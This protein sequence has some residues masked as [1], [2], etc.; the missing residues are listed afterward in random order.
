VSVTGNTGF[1]LRCF[2][3]TNYSGN[4]TG[5]TGNAGGGNVDA[6]GNI[7]GCNRF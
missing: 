6:V 5:V 4:V 3:E 2:A 1:G 7:P